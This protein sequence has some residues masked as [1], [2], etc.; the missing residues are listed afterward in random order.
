MPILNKKGFLK[1]E[2]SNE[3]IISSAFGARDIV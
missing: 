3:Q 1:G 2:L